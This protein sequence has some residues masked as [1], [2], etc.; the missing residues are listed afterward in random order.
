MFEQAIRRTEKKALKL[1]R[2]Q[3]IQEGMNQGIEQGIQQGIQA[4]KD[5][6]AKGILNKEQAKKA[7]E[8]IING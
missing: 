8:T 6:F 3:G 7:E 1:G 5:L 4:I 2:E